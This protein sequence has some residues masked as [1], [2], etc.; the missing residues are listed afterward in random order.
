MF[1][2]FKKNIRRSPYQSLA[3]VFNVSLSL[4]LICVFFLIGAGSQA[5]LNFFESKPQVIAY[6]KDEAKPQEIELLKSK[7]E[8]TNKVKE[9]SFIS[10]DKALEI[11]KDLF[12]DKPVLLEMVTA[13]FLPASLEVSTEDISSLKTVSD[14]LKKE[15][16]VEDVDFQEDVV[17]TL[18]SWLDTLRKFGLAIAGFLLLNCFLTIMVISGM[19]ISQRKDEIETLKLLGASSWYIR[20]PLYFEGVFYGLV[21]AFVSWGL[22]YLAVLYLAPFLK[23]FLAGISIFPVNP[24]FM[25]EVLAGLV[26]LGVSVGFFSSMMAV[27]WFMKSSR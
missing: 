17:S 22:S 19:R 3:V 21:S 9:V 8:Q 7:M 13:K 23:Q 5:I 14:E 2:N 25:L 11:Y 4:F 15:S 18:S 27:F 12:K 26:V 10:K 24:V 20:F 1:K 6:L 16:I